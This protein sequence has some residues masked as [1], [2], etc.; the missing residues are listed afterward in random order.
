MAVLER[1]D[2]AIN[3][4]HSEAREI[5]ELDI[6]TNDYAELMEFAAQFDTQQLEELQ[7]NMFEQTYRGYPLIINRTLRQSGILREDGAEALPDDATAHLNERIAI[8][9]TLLNR[10]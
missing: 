6:T 2:V 10:E 1:L 9:G 4:A 7:L 3:A 8:G 5:I